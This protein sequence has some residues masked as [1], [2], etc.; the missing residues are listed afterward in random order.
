MRNAKSKKWFKS[1]RGDRKEG[2]IENEWGEGEKKNKERKKKKIKFWLKLITSDLIWTKT[3]KK[4][5]KKEWKIDFYLVF[6]KSCMA[7]LEKKCMAINW[8]YQGRIILF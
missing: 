6:L 3:T 2:D 1:K 7:R 4:M 5:K 8:K